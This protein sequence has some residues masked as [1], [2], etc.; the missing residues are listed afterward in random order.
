MAWINLVVLL[1]SAACLL[2]VAFRRPE[3][4][5]GFLLAA[6]VFAAGAAQECETAIE[7]FFP[8]LREPETPVIAAFLA[9]GFALAAANGH[10][11]AAAL[12]AVWRNRRLPLLVW[13]LLCI[14]LVP[15]IAKAKFV[16]E[17][18]SSLDA[19]THDVRETAAAASK[20]LGCL[21]LLNWIV[22]FLKDKWRILV[23]RVP[24]EHEHLLSE[25][26]LVRV[27]WGGTRRNCYRIGDTGFCVKFYKPPED[28]GAGGMK[29]SIRREIARRRFDKFRN[30]SSQEVHIY[31]KLRHAMPAS[32]RER[33][34]P[35]CERVFH[36]EYGWG[37]LET[38]Y[39]NPDGTAVIPYEFEIARQTPERREE[40]YAQASELLDVLV[41]CSAT[42]YE[43]GNFHVLLGADGSV[44]TKIVDFEPTS[45]SAIPLEAFWPWYRRRKLARKAERYL[46]HIRE[47]YG[48]VGKTPAWLAAE[49]TFGVKFTRFERTAF[50]NSSVNYRAVAEDGSEYFVK[51]AP[52]KTVE[53]VERRTASAST[54]LLPGLAFG[55]RTGEF[56]GWRICAAEWRVGE[57]V[58]PADLTPAKAR[59]LLSAHRALLLALQGS[60]AEL[61]R[62]GDLADFDFGVAPCAIHGDMHCRNVM[63]RGD[64]VSAFCDL[65][66]MRIGYP[67][68]DL[69]RVFIHA[70]ERTRFWRSGRIAAICRAFGTLVRESGFP[71][72]AWLAAIALHESRKTRRREAKARF[73]ALKRIERHLRSPYYR[74]LRRTVLESG[75]EEARPK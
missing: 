3:W 39:E 35:V 48:V 41:S 36:P 42:F 58:D 1:A 38:Y 43:P 61:P 53:A 71:R 44:E 40:I 11:T 37:V 15:N 4:R 69:L 59:S 20:T 30:S 28:C 6:F 73:P 33:L 50:G 9:V 54:P 32:V 45:K 49:R 70:L 52:P 47:K 13:G 21:L 8:D 55:G 75:G 22:L 66:M 2:A 19:G 17:A 14:S 10:T 16:W 18:L 74:M 60:A 29:R 72:K 46:A 31:N 64:E 62:P 27:G 67:T 57:C 63:F 34:P 24:S 65:E 26:R 5:G 23:R 51:F 7:P 56:R 68:E 25:H 12:R